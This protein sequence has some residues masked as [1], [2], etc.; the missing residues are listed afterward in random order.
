[1]LDQAH[2]GHTWHRHHI[3]IWNWARVVK[4]KLIHLQTWKLILPPPRLSRCYN[5]WFWV[6]MMAPLLGGMVGSGM[7]LVFIAWHLPDLPTNPPIDSS[8]TKPTTEVWKQP[9]APEK[10][11]VELKT[12]V[13]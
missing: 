5:Y 9:P 13:F 6:P 7:Y 1:M 8:S 4:V 10:E 12:A 3:S 2:D 11:G